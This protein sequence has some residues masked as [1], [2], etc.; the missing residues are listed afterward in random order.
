MNVHCEKIQSKMA[1]K[2][3]PNSADPDQTSLIKVYI[4]SSSINILRIITLW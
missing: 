2:N 3:E 1:I 4:V